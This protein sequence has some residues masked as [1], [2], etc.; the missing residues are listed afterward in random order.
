MTAPRLLTVVLNW[1]TPE[2][3]LR[4]AAAAHR[5]MQGIAGEIVIVDNDSGD[6][7]FETMQAGIAG[8]DRVRVVQSGRNGSFGAGM[9]GSF[10]SLSS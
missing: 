1:R 9:N 6:G 3:S 4:A 5:A 2:M 8:M 10:N 7:S